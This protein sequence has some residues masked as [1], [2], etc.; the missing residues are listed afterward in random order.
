VTIRLST[1][2]ILCNCPANYISDQVTF[3]AFGKSVVQPQ[4]YLDESGEEYGRS[5]ITL[6]R[7]SGFKT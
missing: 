1:T 4:A 5:E 6:I 2:E 7:A 3:Y